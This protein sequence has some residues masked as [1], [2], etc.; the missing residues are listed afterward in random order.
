[1]PRTIVLSDLH[2]RTAPLRAALAHARYSADD[3]LVLAGDL[4]DV[5]NDDVIAYAEELGAVVLAGNHEVAAALGLRIA[6]QHASSLER[7][8]EFAERFISGE[9]PLAYAAG[10]WLITHAGISVTLADIVDRY[11]GDV[12]AIAERLN[13]LFAEEMAQASTEVPLLWESLDRYRIL[14]SSGGPLWFRPIGCEQMASGLR[15]VIGHTAPELYDD[16]TLSGLRACGVLLVESSGH[17]S[18]AAGEQ[19]VDRFLNPSFRYVII[20]DGEARLVEG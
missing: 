5:G 14:G 18:L 12:A 1:M 9:W 8:P 10:D 6:P 4:V 20:E 7:G 16:L 2:G 19:R 15:Q 11:R 3:V 13:E 17:G